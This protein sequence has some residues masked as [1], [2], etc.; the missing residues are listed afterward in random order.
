[1]SSFGIRRISVIRSTGLHA[2]AN[3]YI[4][5]T[6]NKYAAW[7]IFNVSKFRIMN[8]LFDDFVHAPSPKFLL[9]QQ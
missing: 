7:I 5:S 2:H 1:M 9:I 6:L 4:K 8:T 3:S